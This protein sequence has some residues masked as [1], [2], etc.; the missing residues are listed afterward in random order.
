MMDRAESANARAGPRRVMT[1]DQPGRHGQLIRE[2]GGFGSSELRTT[3]RILRTGRVPASPEDDGEKRL[4]RGGW[5]LF[6]E[7]GLDN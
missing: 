3:E 6:E 1:E 7:A 4:Q 5:A 2:K